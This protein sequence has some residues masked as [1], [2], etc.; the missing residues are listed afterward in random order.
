MPEIVTEQLTQEWFDAHRGRISGGTAAGCLRLDPYCSAQKAFRRIKGTEP[1]ISNQW[2]E[3]GTNMEPLARRK[4]SRQ[5][6]V[7]VRETGFWVHNEID[8][9]GAS[10]DGLVGHD[11]MLEIKCPNELPTKCPPHHRIQAAVQLIV[12]GRKW[13]DYFAIVFKRNGPDAWAVADTYQERITVSEVAATGILKRLA[14]FRE[15]YLLTDTV[16]PRKKAKRRR[17]FVDVGG[18][19]IE[20][21]VSGPSPTDMELRE[22]IDIECDKARDDLA[23]K[24]AEPPGFRNATAWKPSDDSMTNVKSDP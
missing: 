17:K 1:H 19:P 5:E 6:G 23:R 13:C 20:L 4:Y 24:A 18:S 12:T 14:A 22:M 2:T 9:L 11:G 15:A 7:L 16:P 21:E 3:W 10:P 8:W